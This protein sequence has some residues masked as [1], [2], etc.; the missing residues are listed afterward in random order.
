MTTTK[1]YKLSKKNYRKIILQTR[2]KKSWWV[3]I[4]MILAGSLYLKNFGKD[5]FSTFFV[6]LAFSY[7]IMI[8]S[9]LI[10]WV[11]SKDLQPIFSETKLT[12][13]ET[14]LYF[15]RNGNESKISPKSF[16]KIISMN[17]FWLIYIAKG[18]FLFVPKDIFYSNDDFNRFNILISSY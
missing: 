5:S 17:S 13:D 8:V 9:Y 3:F 11:N 14:H 18:Q 1:P 2:L 4:L 7:P 6:L 16:Q 10:F 12:F 15:Y